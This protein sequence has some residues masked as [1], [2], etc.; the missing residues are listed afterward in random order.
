MPVWKYRSIEEMPPTPRYERGSAEHLRHWE[1]LWARASA[2][3]GKRFRSGV[4][5]YRSIEEA[6]RSSIEVRDDR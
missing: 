2:L 3:A 4:F 6:Q 1:A 5:R